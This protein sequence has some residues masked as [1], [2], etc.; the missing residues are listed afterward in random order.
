MK[1]DEQLRHDVERELEFDPGI[2][3]RNIAVTAHNGVVALAGHVSTLNDKWQAENIAKR[4][5]GV[6]AVASEIEVKLLDERTDGDIAEDAALALKLDTRIPRDSIKVIVSHGWIT[7]EGVVNYHYQKTAAENAVRT[8]PGVRG[9]T[10]MIAVEPTAISAN[11]VKAS[12]EDTFTRNAQLD[13]NRISVEVRNG[14][15]IL[16]GTVRLWSERE[17]AELGAYRAPGVWQ[18]ENHLEVKL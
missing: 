4:I 18:V 13:A 16:H 12:I 1:T 17:E 11:E 14:K 15:V 10:N 9:I 7:L 6:V 5:S 3:A 8:L 2:D